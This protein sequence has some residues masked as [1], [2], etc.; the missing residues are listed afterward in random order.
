[1]SESICPL[2]VRQKIVPD[3]QVHL[4]GNASAGQFSQL[5]LT[6]GN[7]K[8]PT[9]PATGLIKFP[10]NFGHIV[11]SLKELQAKVF[12]NIQRQLQN[13]SWLCERAIL[14]PKN[15]SVDYINA[16]ILN[17]LPGVAKSYQSIDA[18]TDPN[19][20]VFYPTEFLNSLEPPGLPPHNLL[21]KIGAPILLLRNLDPPRL[22]NGTRLCVKQLFPHVIE[23]TILTG[24]AKGED[25]FIL[26]I[27]LIPTDLAFDFKRVQFPVRLAFAMTIN[28]A[29][30]QT[31]KVAG[32]NLE[33]PCFSHG[34]L[35]VACSRV[36][37]PQNLFI[38]AP[39][40]KTK[41]I[42]YQK[43]LF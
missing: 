40:G 9:D 4:T 33:K 11:D 7:G 37:S 32:I 31:L 25:V 17:Q 35:Y 18:V 1:M 26:R 14:A 34:Q 28:K 43:A 6:L 39:E 20:A 21:L 16:D 2:E 10:P 23:A 38:F 36:G 29:H 41:N 13:Q 30:G 15:K 12:P 22:C 8:A 24:C 27:P 5:L 19:Q 3:N 42:V